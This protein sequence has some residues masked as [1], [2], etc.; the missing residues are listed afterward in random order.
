MSQENV[1]NLRAEPF[2]AGGALG[3]FEAHALRGRGR[4][5]RS[6][7]AFGPMIGPTM[8][9]QTDKDLDDLVGDQPETP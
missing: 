2:M 5:V 3:Y 7:Q 6:W 1:E 8:K 4:D 9:T